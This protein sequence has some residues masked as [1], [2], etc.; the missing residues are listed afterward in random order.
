[1]LSNLAVSNLD[2]R[3]QALTWLA[4]PFTAG[5]EPSIEYLCQQTSGNYQAITLFTETN[6]DLKK[7]AVMLFWK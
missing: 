3:L 7:I 6:N 2:L 1:M 5:L 4:G